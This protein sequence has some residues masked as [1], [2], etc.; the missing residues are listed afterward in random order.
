MSSVILDG[1]AGNNLLQTTT[2]HIFIYVDIC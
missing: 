1:Q 2:L